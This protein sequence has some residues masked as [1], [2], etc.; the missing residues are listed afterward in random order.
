MLWVKA[1][2][3]ACTEAYVD[4]VFT[5]EDGIAAA[6]LVVGDRALQEFLPLNPA[7]RSTKLSMPVK[8]KEL[9]TTAFKAVE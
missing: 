9:G 8:A 4:K 6:I 2:A 7:R 1:P 3:P 5:R